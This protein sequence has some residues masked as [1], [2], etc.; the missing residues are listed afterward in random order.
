[1]ATF[2]EFRSLRRHSIR[3]VFAPYTMVFVRKLDV[4]SICMYV[5]IICACGPSLTLG[6]WV[7]LVVGGLKATGGWL[8]GCGWVG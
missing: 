7:W 1:M 5:F 2:Q 3:A 8:G 4:A 6:P